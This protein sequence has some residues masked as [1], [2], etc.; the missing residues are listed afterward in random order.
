MKLSEKIYFCRKK[1][2]KSQEALAEQLG[3]SRQ[4]VSKW[5][6]GDSEPEIGKLKLLADAF[7]VTVDWLLSEDEPAEETE[8]EP[9][10]APAAQTNTSRA[11]SIFGAVGT[12]LRRYG[13][14]LGIG[15]AL[16]GAGLTINGVL[17]HVVTNRMFSFIDSMTGGMFGSLGDDIAMD[18]EFGNQVSGMVSDFA[19]NN[20][21]STMGTANI[22][23]GMILIVCGVV[24]AVVL[25]KR[26]QRRT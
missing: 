14:L 18:D 21:V 7:G 16:V 9:K 12:L 20:P 13:W 22:V 3:V 6:T 5:E 23:I 11:D 15:I 8:N 26:N 1:S 25:K 17:A 19:A 24:L 4:A 2:G 10:P